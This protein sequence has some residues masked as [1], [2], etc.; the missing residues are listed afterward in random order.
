MVHGMVDGAGV[1]WRISLLGKGTGSIRRHSRGVLCGHSYGG[2]VI[3]GAVEEI[4]S[5]VSSIVFLDAH[6]PKNGQS[7]RQTS[8]HHHLIEDSLKKRLICTQPPKAAEFQVNESDQSWVDAKL[9]PQPIGVSLQEIRL[10]GARERVQR[11]AYIRATGFNSDTF[12][13]YFGAAK[14]SQDWRTYEVPTGHDVMIDMPER[15]AEILCDAA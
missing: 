1:E 6:V 5:R 10:T 15:L 14:A 13:G 12:D 8:N 9:T 7:G 4:E 2:W 3:S 11:K